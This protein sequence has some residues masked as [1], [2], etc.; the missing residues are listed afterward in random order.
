[1]LITLSKVLKYI[2]SFCMLYILLCILL[3]SITY[4][5]YFYIF[6][7]VIVMRMHYL[8]SEIYKN[9]LRL[10]VIFCSKKFGNLVL[11]GRFYERIIS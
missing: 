10:S 11:P 6:L 4:S 3:C 5:V 7:K 9:E 8:N 1:M 2:L